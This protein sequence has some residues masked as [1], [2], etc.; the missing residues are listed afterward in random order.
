MAKRSTRQGSG[1]GKS[2]ADDSGDATQG[3]VGE[4]AADDAAP[5]QLT[6]PAT[7]TAAET[8][9]SVPVTGTPSLSKSSAIDTPTT[10]D[11]ETKPAATTPSPSKTTAASAAK[12]GPSKAASKA[13]ATTA[14]PS[15]GGAT[16]AGPS[17]A[18]PSKAGPSKASPS[19]AGATKAGLAKGGSA[20]TASKTTPRSRGRKPPPVV[21]A[22][23]K[24][25]GW[26]AAAVAVVVFAVAA[27]GYA[28]VQA[29]EQAALADP[30]NIEG[31]QTMTF[32]AQQH[33]IEPVAYEQ[34]PPFG[35]LHDIVWADCT[36]V[37]Y[38][39]QIRNENAV[40]SLEHGAVWVTYDPALPQDQIDTL[41]GLVE[42]EGFTMMSPYEGLSSPIS[43]QAW[44]NQ[45]FVESAADPRIAQFITALRQNP[46]NTPEPGATC[47]SPAFAANPIPE[48]SPGSTDPSAPVTTDPS[49][50]TDP[51]ATTDPTA[52]TA[53]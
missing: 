53:P 30:N 32:E 42:G 35:G 14:S 6:K 17:K 26:I 40:H 25:W 49:A 7:S 12:A 9:P 8:G 50:T 3:T 1:T 51:A 24:P 4:T 39:I 20:K 19:K 43:L 21:A 2:T 41:A 11:A 48:E 18:G 34:S 27:I 15:T 33:S 44:G 45:L 22:K 52:T 29:N 37:V 38:P 23:P 10:N 16:K 28:V 5:A 46:A 13:V 31:L 47:D 36:G